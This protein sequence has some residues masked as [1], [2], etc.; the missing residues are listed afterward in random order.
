[1]NFNV[2]LSSPK[3][4]N[5]LTGLSRLSLSSEEI[6]DDLIQSK[7]IYWHYPVN[8]KQHHEKM[9]ENTMLRKRF[10]PDIS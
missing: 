6:G 9:S 4:V 7:L 3:L 8:T 10:K 2:R 5:L 1:M